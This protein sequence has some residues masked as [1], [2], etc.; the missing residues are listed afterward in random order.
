MCVCVCVRIAWTRSHGH[1]PPGVQD[2]L[3]EDLETFTVTLD[4]V[5]GGDVGQ[6]A[7]APAANT[8]RIQVRPNDDACGRFAMKAATRA[9]HEAQG[10]VTL[11]L[12][13]EVGSVG[14]A[15]VRWSTV[16]GE[17]TALQGADFEDQSRVAVFLPGQ[18]EANV[19]VGVVLGGAGKRVSGW[20]CPWGWGGLKPLE[21]RERRGCMRVRARSWGGVEWCTRLTRARTRLSTLSR[22]WDR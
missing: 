21:Y 13:R 19:T 14:L 22:A 16:A 2:T 20:A 1:S 15:S 5:L 4:R 7:I 12:L 17:G 3:P 18:T 9:V 8:A 6:S 10:Q 11:H